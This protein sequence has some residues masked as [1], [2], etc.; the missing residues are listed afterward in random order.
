MTTPAD[1]QKPDKFFKRA[2]KKVVPQ[3]PLAELGKVMVWVAAFGVLITGFTRGLDAMHIKIDTPIG[4]IYENKDA[5][6]CIE[7]N[8][9]DLRTRLDMLLK[10]RGLIPPDPPKTHP[11]AD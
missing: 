1:D 7:T 3:I 8:M 11:V 6:K 10:A 9:A 4:Q 2:R 5:I